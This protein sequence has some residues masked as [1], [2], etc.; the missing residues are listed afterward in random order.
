MTKQGKWFET[1]LRVRY[2]ETDQMHVVYHANYLSW[3]E[4]GRT[5][6]IRK[7]G[8][9]YRRFEDLGYLLPLNETNLKFKSP[10]HY[11]EEI[12]IKTRIILCTGICLVFGYEIRR[13]EDDGDQ[14][15]VLGETHHAWTTKE[16][17]PVR[18]DK[19]E[20]HIYRLMK[21]YE[22]SGEESHA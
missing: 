13:I 5:E 11:D 14:L 16:L 2:S 12:L 9:P 7:L 20:P 1:T 15:L 8:F 4:V 22:W 21:E 6:L 10:A 18:I 19:R 17:K 3:F